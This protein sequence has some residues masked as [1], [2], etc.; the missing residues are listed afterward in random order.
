MKLRKFVRVG[1]ALVAIA[2]VAAAC[3]SS[4][5]KASSSTAKAASSTPASSSVTGTFYELYQSCPSNPFW[6]AVNNGGKAAAKRLGVNLKIE[7]PIHCKGEIP[8]EESLLT[9]IINS[10]PAGIAL[11]LVSNTAF[12][13]DIQKARALHIPIIA[14][15]SVPHDYNHTN[16]PVEAYVGQSNYSAGVALAQKSLKTYNLGSSSKVLIVDN[17]AINASCVARVNGFKSVVDPKGV[18]VSTVD[19]HTNVSASIGI[20]K[21]DFE[22]HGRPSLVVTLGSDGLEPAVK[23][24]KEMGYKPSQLPFVGFDFDP[25]SLKYMQE[26]WYRLTVDQQPFLQGYDALVDLYTAAKFKSYPINMAT[27]PV[28]VQNNSIDKTKGWLD[29]SVVKST[30]I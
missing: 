2:M 9:T 17:C 30:G 15:N 21:A 20:V 5:P 23:A 18:K 7:D 28:Y 13:A 10:H 6:V 16:N 11:S 25:V 12:S 26:G 4:S 29:Q 19:V 8:Q 27:G 24:A 14:Y 22:A 1:G 3:G